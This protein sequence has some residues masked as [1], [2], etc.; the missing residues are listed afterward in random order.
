MTE[1]MTQLAEGLNML[2]MDEHKVFFTQS[3]NFILSVNSQTD[4][5][6]LGINMSVQV[7]A[8][9]VRR[10]ARILLVWS[11][12]VAYLVHWNLKECALKGSGIHSI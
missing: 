3:L 4:L 12:S 5:T 8:R 1:L 2:N 7:K 6:G 9:Y 10:Y 11:D